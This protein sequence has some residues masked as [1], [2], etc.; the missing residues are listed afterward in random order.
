MPKICIPEDYLCPITHEIME[1]PVATEDGLIYERKA[2][3]LWLSK[4]N[5]SPLTGL[6]LNSKQLLVIPFVKNQINRFL[7]ENKIC[8]SD[9]FLL[10]VIIGNKEKLE[11]LIYTDEHLEIQ[12][13]EGYGPVHLAISRKHSNILEFLLE[14]DF[15]FENETNKGNTPLHIAAFD[16][17][18]EAVNLLLKKGAIVDAINYQ[19][20]TPAHLASL[21]GKT[22]ILE[23]LFNYGAN[24]KL[25]NIEKKEPFD[26]AKDNKTSFFIKTLIMDNKNENMINPTHRFFKTPDLQTNVVSFLPTTE[27]L[28]TYQLISR[29]NEE[30]TS[31]PHL[32]ANL[33]KRDFKIDASTLGLSDE[34]ANYNFYKTCF[35]EKQFVF[36]QNFISI[37]KEFQ[38]SARKMISFLDKNSDWALYFEFSSKFHDYISKNKHTILEKEAIQKLFIQ[39]LNTTNDFVFERLCWLVAN[40]YWGFDNYFRPLLHKLILELDKHH[41]AENETIYRARSNMLYALYWIKI[42]EKER[43]DEYGESM[44]DD[45][46]DFPT[47][48]LFF[49]L[50]TCISKND[51]NFYPIFAKLLLKPCVDSWTFWMNLDYKSALKNLYGSLTDEE[52]I[53]G[54]FE[55]FLIDIYTKLA[56]N[57]FPFKSIIMPSLHEQIKNSGI[58]TIFLMEH[59]K[60]RKIIFEIIEY[61]PKLFTHSIL[62][63]VLKNIRKSNM[64][65]SDALKENESLSNLLKEIQEF[66]TNREVIE[67]ITRLYHDDPK[68]LCSMLPMIGKTSRSY[69]SDDEENNKYYNTRS[70]L[71]YV[72]KE[73]FRINERLL[74]QER[75]LQ[76]KKVI[77]HINTTL[78]ETF[79]KQYIDSKRGVWKIE[80]LGKGDFEATFV[81]LSLPKRNDCEWFKAKL[82]K[83]G[84]DKNDIHFDV[85]KI[86]T[87]NRYQMRITNLQLLKLN[88]PEIEKRLHL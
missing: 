14:N 15:P 84:I 7:Q 13:E 2:I 69:L 77:E 41:N 75:L 85:I 76:E 49:A 47:E 53:K 30:I 46:S 34:E 52:E 1:N 48:A 55:E 73:A 5:T 68:Q 66:H 36:Q 83:A 70:N 81:G 71:I 82:I 54:G 33:L 19:K 88:A 9:E 64:K 72:E 51:E 24:F 43:E 45:E 63:E 44:S 40:H 39:L 8:S 35:L 57:Y 26:V 32:W 58:P 74:L 80:R 20:N 42:R 87:E 4:H 10:S 62:E 38:V 16:G 22:E 18:V 31:A 79:I 23:L 12:N 6:A 29:D 78:G 11:K 25:Q 56:A 50:L 28:K 21:N 61:W 67:D 17:N 60:E 27:I 86:K 59:K 65:E 37:L 3:E